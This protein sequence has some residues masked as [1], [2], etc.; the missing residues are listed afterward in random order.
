MRKHIL[1]GQGEEFDKLFHRL[2]HLRRVKQLRTTQYHP[3]TN[4]ALERMNF[5]IYSMLRT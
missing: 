4:G 3:Q 5:T 2:K 1:H